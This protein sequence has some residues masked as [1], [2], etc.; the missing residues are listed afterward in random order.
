MCGIAG[1]I[2]KTNKR[3]DRP[4]LCDIQQSLAHRGP[5]GE[6]NNNSRR[7]G[8][9]MRR[10]SIID[11]KTGQQP[12][13]D[14]SGNVEV[15]ANGEIYNY[16]ELMIKLKKKGHKFKTK[17][18][19]ETINHLYE[20]F[21]IDFIS[22][23]RGMFAIALHDKRRKLVYLIR[24][25]MGEKPIYWT[26]TPGGIVF[27]SEM[28]ALLKA[29]GVNKQLNYSGIDKYFHYYYIPEPE[30]MFKNVNKIEAGSY[31]KINL[32]DLSTEKIKYWKPEDIS[33][34]FHGD[35]TEKIRSIFADSCKLTLRSDV[36]VGIS[37][38]GGIDSGAI[39][40]YSAPYYK[41]RMRAFS[42]GYEGSPP[43]DEREMARKL[44]KKFKVDF[45]QKELN[46][47]TIVKDFPRLVWNGDDPIADIA[48]HGILAV[49][50]LAKENGVSV[51]LGGI[52][53]DELFWGYPWMSDAVNT[54]LRQNS[55]WQTKIFGKKHRMYFYDQNPGYI[56]AKNFSTKLYDREFQKKLKGD[57]NI[58]VM[59]ASQTDLD[60]EV[61]VGRKGM[62]LIRNVWLRSN[63]IALNDRL[64]MAASVE[65][66]SPFLDYKL[67][68][69]ALS[70]SKNV[71]SFNKPPKYYFKKAMKGV[72]PDEVLRRKK[73]GFTPP[74]AEWV[75]AINDKYIGYLSNGFLVKNNILDRRKVAVLIKTWKTLPMYWYP[76]YQTILLEIWGREFVFG[77]KPEDLI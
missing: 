16:K 30:T 48:G 29:K 57:N 52:G 35:P 74:V 17:S 67:V 3:T 49:N 20:D 73:R 66:R 1:V 40:A 5:D 62:E 45:V 28:K 77:Q 51:L 2:S 50:N 54:T 61:G 43:S 65:L 56:S 72:V 14:E 10:L 42:I 19:I 37:L 71:T 76:V 44:A 12:L 7:V 9:A 60:N 69:F 59:Y 58:K 68:E 39:L 21:G 4:M 31:L 64:S 41:D 63:C 13:Y 46:T 23:L 38:S 70:S 22:Q 8:L 11:V 18:D 47:N 15:I 27:A 53:G 33:S 34:D 32:K 36:S 26:K 24:D 25:R 55:S 75:K 6:G